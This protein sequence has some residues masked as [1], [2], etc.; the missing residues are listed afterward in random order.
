[1][2]IEDGVYRPVYLAVD[3]PWGVTD[4]IR[5]AADGDDLPAFDIGP[6][7]FPSTPITVLAPPMFNASIPLDAMVFEW[8]PG[9]P[10]E[11]VHIT[12]SSDLTGA[13][14]ACTATDDGHFQVPQAAL[15]SRFPSV[16]DTL[17]IYVNRG[18]TEYFE[19]APEV[20]VGLTGVTRA[21]GTIEMTDA[22]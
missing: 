11:D 5:A 14:M 10:A 13:S 12:L 2:P 16:P 4:A 7:P 9:T 15:E 3:V 21:Y 1:M 20:V 18:D 6:I 19:I 22:P 17:R 8:E